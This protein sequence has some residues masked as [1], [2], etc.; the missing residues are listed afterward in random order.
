MSDDDVLVE[1]SG[2]HKSFGE[3]P[4]TRVEVL[5]G[6]DLTLRRGELV[7]LVG[8]S[9]SG[10][11]T[12]LNILGL[13]DRATTGIL[14]IR[15]R[16]VSDMSDAELTS[17]R[18]EVLGFVF[19]F[20]HLLPGLTVAENVMLPAAAREGALAPTQRPRAVDLL[21][22]VGL[23]DQADRYARQLSGGM[24]QRVAVVRALMNSPLVVYADEPTGNLDTESSMRVM[25]FLVDWNRRE[26]TTFVIVTH[27]PDIARRC[28]R[29]LRMVDGHLV[30][31][32]PPEDVLR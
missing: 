15:G 3:A 18:A 26:R 21:G 22:H 5:H 25:D 30:A 11:S 13:L 2:V 28:R 4:E 9:G 8:P 1:L 14:R 17:L 27:D 16:D 6:I 12:L 10:K 29:V 19:Q 20:H 32:G 24:Q 23:A 7:A 31:D